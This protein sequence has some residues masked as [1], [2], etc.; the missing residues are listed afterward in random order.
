MY[1]LQYS[2]F[3]DIAHRIIIFRL[4]YCYNADGFVM[5]TFEN[6]L[7]YCIGNRLWLCHVFTLTTSWSF[8]YDHIIGQ[9]SSSL[10]S[11]WKKYHAEIRRLLTIN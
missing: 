8:I 11:R 10:G 2:I 3:C 5:T 6:E 4:K 1:H 7:A 9:W